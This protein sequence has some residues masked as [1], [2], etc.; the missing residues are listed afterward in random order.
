MFF[1]LR[2]QENKYGETYVMTNFSV[3]YET[4][5]NSKKSDDQKT[6]IKQCNYDY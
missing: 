1:S 2:C 3:I 4:H 6:I 5:V